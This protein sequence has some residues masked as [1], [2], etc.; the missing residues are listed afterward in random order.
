MSDDQYILHGPPEVEVPA[1]S[2]YAE[3][4]LKGLETGGNAIA[5]VN[6]LTL[7]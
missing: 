4:M 1:V 5:Q 7:V 6:K 3:H 2:S